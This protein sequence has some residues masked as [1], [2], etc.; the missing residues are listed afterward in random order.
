[1]STTDG[2]LRSMMGLRGTNRTGGNWIRPSRCEHQDHPATDHV[3]KA[4]VGL[5]PVPVLAQ[6][7]RKTP[8]AQARVHGN[9]PANEDESV[10][11]DGAVAVA[12]A[13][14]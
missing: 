13:W 10:S 9:E 7:G 11:G 3:A 6:L 2:A 14:P 4:A 12:W 5:H 1:M 8:A